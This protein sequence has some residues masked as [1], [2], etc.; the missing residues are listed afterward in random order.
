VLPSATEVGP[1]AGGLDHR[2]PSCETE[3]RPGRPRLVVARR[4]DPVCGRRPRHWRPAGPGVDA[5]ICFTVLPF[6]RALRPSAAEDVAVV[7]AARWANSAVARGRWVLSAQGGC[8]PSPKADAV[9]SSEMLVVGLKNPVCRS[10]GRR[11]CRQAAV[12]TKPPGAKP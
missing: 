12:W 8:S 3:H 1:V 7:G 4:P 5:A 9:W 10:A 6:A 11:W 2:F